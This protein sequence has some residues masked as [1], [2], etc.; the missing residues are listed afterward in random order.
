MGPLTETIVTDRTV[1]RDDASE[2][3]ID[4]T[5]SSD[6]GQ[7]NAIHNDVVPESLISLVKDSRYIQQCQELLEQICSSLLTG[8]GLSS[9][10]DVL[11]RRTWLL[12]YLL[13]ILL[14]VVP[15]G[16]S[17]GLHLFNLSFKDAIEGDSGQGSVVTKRR[18]LYFVGKLLMT[19]LVGYGL[20]YCATMRL[21]DDGNNGDRAA[22]D[23]IRQENLRGDDRR[24]MHEKLRRQMMERARGHVEPV[25]TTSDDATILHSNQ[26]MR[27]QHQTRGTSM[28]SIESQA[29][30]LSQ[31]LRS[32]LR[33]LSKTILD[34]LFHAEGPHILADSN[35]GS[36]SGSGDV[37]Y[38][39]ASWLIRLHLAQ[40]LV[41]GRFP[42]ITHRFLGMQTQKDANPP[43]AD[44]SATIQFRPNTNRIIAG[45]IILK[46]SASSI[47]TISN[48]LAKFAANFLERRAPSVLHDE[49]E[50]GILSATA[51]LDT[52]MS[53]CFDIPHTSNGMAKESFLGVSSP[54][55]SNL[56]STADGRGGGSWSGTV[57]A[58]CHTNRTHPA[59]PSTCGHVC[60]WNCLVHWVSTVRPECPLCRAPCRPQEVIPLYHYEPASSVA[61]DGYE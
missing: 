4:S 53:K 38:S 16:R 40:Y 3:R 20:D 37:Y 60:C 41:T 55:G 29:S 27:T 18:R 59:A 28:Q 12:S 7:R 31:T 8:F 10:Q 48:Q 39:M 45:L 30:S 26:E 42:T 61:D 11:R 56:L 2:T 36:L 49:S 43:N 34:V 52:A 46:A 50:Q 47:R 32:S 57:C 1:N 9:E 25:R 15:S 58:I 51:Q 19:V 13:Y 54:V 23:R 14:V 24:Q 5:T 44:G 21:H 33:R 6:E 35:V 17:L 22:A